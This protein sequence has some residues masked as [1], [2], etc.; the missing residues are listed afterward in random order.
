MT[1]SSHLPSPVLPPKE[2]VND[3]RNAGN[4][5][6]IMPFRIE[7]VYVLLG[8]S[9]NKS[10]LGVATCPFVTGWLALLTYV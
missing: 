7:W 2:T 6:I 10:A 4:E 8:D 1:L 3:E 9:H 5:D